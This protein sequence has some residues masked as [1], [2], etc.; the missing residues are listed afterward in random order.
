MR[1]IDV[2]QT[3]GRC[4]EIQAYLKYYEELGA[5][6]VAE[7]SSDLDEKVTN[8]RGYMQQIREYNLDFDVTSL[9]KIVIDL[10]S[11]IY[12]TT[13][14]LEKLR[15]MSDMSKIK[16]KN[17]YNNAYLDKQAGAK[18]ED[19]KYTADQLRA[20]AEEEAL[21]D[22]LVNFIYERAS[23]VL[24]SKLDAAR[25]V[26]KACSKCLSAQIQSMSTFGAA[27]RYDR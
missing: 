12:Y 16:Y 26:L 15:L 6:L 7:Y 3:K 22:N 21:E 8:I 11:C 20:I 18:L 23:A 25:E 9:Q 1:E 19:R 17:V 27:S 13:E 4:D 2:E 14:K 24:A 5:P 10:S